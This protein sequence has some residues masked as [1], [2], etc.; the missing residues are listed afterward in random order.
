MI[1]RGK[2]ENAAEMGAYAKQLTQTLPRPH[3]YQPETTKPSWK[4]PTAAIPTQEFDDDASDVREP[5]S[6]IDL[7]VPLRRDENG[8]GFRVVGG[9]EEGTQ[10]SVGHI[11]PGGAAE[12]DGRLKTGDEILTVDCETSVGAAH[13]ETVQAIQQAS[14][15]GYV[16]LGVRRRFDM[17]NVNGNGHELEMV[18]PTQ[19]PQQPQMDFQRPGGM[20]NVRNV[21]ITRQVEEGFGFVLVSSMSN[22]SG[23]ESARDSSSGYIAYPVIGKILVS[24]C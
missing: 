2:G 10:V 3:P 19:Q 13:Q 14:E 1:S 18:Q 11:V 21:T 4:P 15:K 6:Y 7:C 17:M 12:A 16:V 8:F 9:R 5:P 24:Y 22:G 23:G 20:E